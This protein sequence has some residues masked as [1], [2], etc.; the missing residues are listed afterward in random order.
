VIVRAESGL[1]IGASTFS[2]LDSQTQ[3]DGAVTGTTQAEVGLDAQGEA[4]FALGSSL[5]TLTDGQVPT[6]WTEEDYVAFVFGATGLG[7]LVGTAAW[8]EFVAANLSD[9]AASLNPA[10]MDLSMFDPFFPDG[11]QGLTTL[12]G[13]GLALHDTFKA[14]QAAGVTTFSTDT[15]ETAYL[16]SDDQGNR[17]LSAV[18]VD[19]AGVPTEAEI[20]FARSESSA[21][22]K[23]LGKAGN[24]AKWGE[25]AG[26]GSVA[27]GAGAAALGEVLLPLAAAASI[28]YMDEANIRAEEATAKAE[29]VHT[30]FADTGSEV[31]LHRHRYQIAYM[32]ETVLN[33]VNSGDVAGAAD[34][35]LQQEREG[36][37]PIVLRAVVDGLPSYAGSDVYTEIAGRVGN[38]SYF[39]ALQDGREYSALEDA[40]FAHGPGRMTALEG[41]LAVDPALAAEAQ[42]TPIT[43]L[44]IARRLQ[45]LPVDAAT[46]LVS[47]WARALSGGQ[48]AD[49]GRFAEALTT[50]KIETPDQFAAVVTG[51]LDA[52]LPNFA[53]ML[54]WLSDSG[55]ADVAAN[56]LDVLSAPDQARVLA[57]AIGVGEN[58]LRGVIASQGGLL[59]EMY[60]GM[61]AESKAGLATYLDGVALAQDHQADFASMTDAASRAAYLDAITAPGPLLEGVTP[62]DAKTAA[63]AIQLAQLSPTE[64]ADV[65]VHLSD[66]ETGVTGESSG[67]D[68]AD[69]TQADPPGGKTNGLDDGDG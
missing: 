39:A 4:V 38:T 49:D 18:G 20:D 54:N 31:P 58:D 43:G 2:V 14:M 50:L 13:D 25:A 51:V 53:A 37:S 40:A 59:E 41:L 63:Q 7:D 67:A 48:M 42:D 6:D 9:P 68:E 10:D 22:V 15:F 27:E 28:N 5:V 36:T 47:Q 30:A 23:G 26:E 19:P 69:G 29:A 52:S 34:F 60:T 65:L 24:A 66:P 57:Y 56:M 45:S 8:D 46:R 55:K 61:T 62:E 1:V 33:L 12:V 32:T 44:V 21:A 3:I 17:R 35:L 64:A 11:T 16:T